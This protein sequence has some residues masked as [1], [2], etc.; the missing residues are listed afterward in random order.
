VE[1]HVHAGAVEVTGTLAGHLL[2]GTLF[3][4]W[5]LVWMSQAVVRRDPDRGDQ[6]LE[7]GLAMPVLKIVLP[8]VGMWA[9]IPGQGW[10]PGRGWP[11]DAILMNW[12][13]VTMY[14]VFALSG[15]VDLLARRGA[16]SAQATL[17]TYAAAHANAGF[18]FWAHGAHGGV[19]GVVHSLL[20]LAFAGAAGTALVELARPSRGTAWARRGALLAVGA[21]FIVVGWILYVSA[22]DLGDRVRE[23]WSYM[24]FSWTVAAVAAVTI[25]F[26][27]IA[28][29]RARG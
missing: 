7:S 11:A 21:W 4:V 23:G 13:H 5:A 16:L 25:A 8:V 29:R 18:L 9:E 19:P 3:I 2:P 17:A 1:Q 15:M 22:W 10:P 14:G 27:V 6:P 26:R 20:V 12:Q 24:L 28:G